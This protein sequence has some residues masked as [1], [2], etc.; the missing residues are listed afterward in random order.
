MLVLS[1][2]RGER[3]VIGDNVEL[4]IISVQ[5]GRVKLGFLAPDDVAIYREEVFQRLK[6]EE[7]GNSNEYPVSPGQ[8][9]SLAV[10]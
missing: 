10:A 4:V 2:K 6:E 1:R 5:G 3:I 7:D 8:G 9:S